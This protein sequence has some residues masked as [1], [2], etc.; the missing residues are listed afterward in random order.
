MKKILIAGVALIAL[1]SVA[2]G[3]FGNPYLHLSPSDRHIYKNRKQ[4]GNAILFGSDSL[5]N[6]NKKRHESK[7]R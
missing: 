7:L 1:G 6:K 4:S 2:R 5:F 3:E